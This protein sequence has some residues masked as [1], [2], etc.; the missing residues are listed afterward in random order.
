MTDDPNRIDWRAFAA[1]IMRPAQPRLREAV[2]LVRSLA[3]GRIDELRR[4]GEAYVDDWGARARALA[5]PSF[6]AEAWEA[7]TQRFDAEA[8]FERAMRGETCFLP[9]TPLIPLTDLADKRPAIRRTGE[10]PFELETVVAMLAADPGQ[11]LAVEALA[12]EACHRM[13]I[14]GV[15]GV[16]RVAWKLERR[17]W[18]YGYAG[19]GW[20][21]AFLSCARRARSDLS[22]FSRVLRLMDIPSSEGPTA[23]RV[24]ANMAAA[25]LDWP[26]SPLAAAPNAFDPLL[27]LWGLGYVPL[28]I[29][30]DLVI[31]GVTLPED[32]DPLSAKDFTGRLQEAARRYG[33]EQ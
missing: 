15:L 18:P 22:Q 19:S 11:L 28:D 30:R 8:L 21:N 32:V 24:A 14:D 4:G 13:A 31:V 26:S 29:R 1:G 23:R 7:A 33:F 2:A 17:A 6:V 9:A 25:W 3:D 16:R 10:G 12:L 20:E 27:V 5:E